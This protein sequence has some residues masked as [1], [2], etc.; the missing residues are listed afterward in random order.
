MHKFEAEDGKMTWRTRYVPPPP[1]I[2]LFASLSNLGLMIEKL[3]SPPLVKRNPAFS[4]FF[5]INNY[6]NCYY[7]QFLNY[8]FC[9]GLFLFP[10]VMSRHCRL[11]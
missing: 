4:P 3:S 5:I 10:G 6:C 1:E 9:N 7:E 8:L 2:A 11:R